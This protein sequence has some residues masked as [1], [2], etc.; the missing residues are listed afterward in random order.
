MRDSVKK[1]VTNIFGNDAWDKICTIHA[2][3]GSN[4]ITKEEVKKEMA[5]L[6]EEYR[7]KV[8]KGTSVTC[9]D[10]RGN[11][12]SQYPKHKN[13]LLKF[14]KNFYFDDFVYMYDI[15][16]FSNC[17]DGIVFMVSGIYIPDTDFSGRTYIAYKDIKTVDGYA[18]TTITT[19]NH[20]LYSIQDIYFDGE[21]LKELISKLMKLSKKY[22]IDVSVSPTGKVKGLRGGARYREGY[23]DGQVNGYQRCSREYEIKLRRQAELFL[24]EKNKWKVARQEYEALLDEYEVTIE[25]LETKVAELKWSSSNEYTEYKNRLNNMVVLQCKLEKLQYA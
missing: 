8:K 20:D 18:K 11:Y 4:K 3:L 13:N 7:F 25:D 22:G 1:F 19:K 21:H 12:F 24:E 17:K 15:S 14:D 23:S 16:F 9:K 2:H 6:I 10:F 5:K